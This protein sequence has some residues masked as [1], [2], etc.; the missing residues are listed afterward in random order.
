MEVLEHRSAADQGSRFLRVWA[1]GGWR[2]GSA[3]VSGGVGTDVGQTWDTWLHL[4]SP[5]SQAEA[6]KAKGEAAHLAGAMRF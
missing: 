5:G 3:K 4:E 1:P 2:W 6:Q